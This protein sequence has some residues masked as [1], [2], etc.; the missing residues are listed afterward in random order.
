ML[1][2]SGIKI[3]LVIIC[4]F[5]AYMQIDGGDVLAF[6]Y[7]DAGS[8]GPNDV[9][10]GKTI[11]EM[12][13]EKI[14][15]VRRHSEYCAIKFTRFWTGKTEEDYFAIYESHCQSDKSGDF[16]KK[17]IHFKREK[18]SFPKPRGIGRLA[19]SHGNKEIKCGSFRLFWAGKGSVHFFGEDQKDG[20]Y[21][22]ELAPTKWTNIS[23]VNVFDPRLKWYRYD[24]NRKRINIP[25]DQLWKDNKGN[26]PR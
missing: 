10:I 15:L 23:E 20:D 2:V 11:I 5:I 25:A 3:I 13:L 18:L 24:E 4:C 22:I 6:Y 21:G 19:F 17:N 16:S 9:H 14:L 7:G 26:K 8:P 12:P 1:R